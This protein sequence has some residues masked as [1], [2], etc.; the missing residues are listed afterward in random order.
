LLRSYEVWCSFLCLAKRGD[1]N[2]GF[3]CLELSRF[4]RRDGVLRLLVGV[5]VF[6]ELGF[7]AELLSLSQR[8]GDRH[9]QDTPNEKDR[10]CI[11]YI[12]KKTPC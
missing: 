9:T 3:V 7:G 4:C 1:G 6:A 10:C 8:R 5:C 11:S 2:L 12:H